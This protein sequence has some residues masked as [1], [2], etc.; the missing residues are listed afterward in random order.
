MN[1]QDAAVTASTSSVTASA[2]PVTLTVDSTDGFQ[3][4]MTVTIDAYDSDSQEAE[5]ITAIPDNTH[6]EVAQLK[7]H[8]DG[9]STPFPIVQPGEAGVVIA[10][11]YE[12]TP[13]HVTDIALATPFPEMS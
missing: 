9:T 1:S 2:D 8:H 11:W 7:N 3:V 13:S 5:T 12:Y 6:I 10:E 4:G